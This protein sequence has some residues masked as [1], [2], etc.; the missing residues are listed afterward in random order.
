M[1]RVIVRTDDAGMACNVGGAVNSS[2]KTFDISAPEVEAFL[3][4]SQ[5]TYGQRQ[6]VGV[7]ITDQQS[8]AGSN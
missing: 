7:E 6:V 3:R 5:G 8:D 2:F 4:A 1:L